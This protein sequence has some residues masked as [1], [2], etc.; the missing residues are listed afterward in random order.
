MASQVSVLP[1]GTTIV[2]APNAKSCRPR[3]K[4]AAAPLMN[5]GRFN[6]TSYF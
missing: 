1:G 4:R 2:A 3:N 5:E 6:P